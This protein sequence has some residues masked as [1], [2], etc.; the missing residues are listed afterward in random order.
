M[1]LQTQVAHFISLLTSGQAERAMEEYYHD[2]IVVFEN[3]TLARA[4]KR[5][6]LTYEREQLATQR[7]APRYKLRG[8]A[9]NDATGHVFLEYSVRFT[10]AEGRPMRLDEVAVQTWED[11]KIV[12]ERFYYEGLVDEGD[13]DAEGSFSQ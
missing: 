12:Q 1:A 4:G 3:R 10:D 11:Q 6:C 2:E 5:A 9:V 8:H 13:L 7:E